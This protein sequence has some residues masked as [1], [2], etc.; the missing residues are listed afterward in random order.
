MKILT[1][2]AAVFMAIFCCAVAIGH[3]DDTLPYGLEKVDSLKGARKALLE[4]RNSGT[5]SQD[6]MMDLARKMEPDLRGKAL[7]KLGVTDQGENPFGIERSGT[8]P[9]AG[10]GIFSD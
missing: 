1:V 8:S 9:E 10:R 7:L 5:I 3:A 6:K 2:G 4:L